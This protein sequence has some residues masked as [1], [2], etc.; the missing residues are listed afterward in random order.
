[1]RRMAAGNTPNARR[2]A[3]AIRTER[4]PV[5]PEKGDWPTISE[6]L[7]V[8]LGTEQLPYF[9][10]W[11]KSAIESYRDDTPGRF[12]PSQ[13]VILIGEPSTGKNFT[14][15]YIITP[16][17][18]RVGDPTEWLLNSQASFNS[19]WFGK[20]HLVVCDPPGGG[21]KRVK[22]IFGAKLKSL[23]ANECHRFHAKGKDAELMQ[24][25][26]VVTISANKNYHSRAILPYVLASDIRDKLLV[27]DWGNE[28]GPLPIRQNEREAFCQRITS[29]LPS[30]AYHILNEFQIPEEITDRFGRFAV[31]GYCA[32][33]L[34]EI[35]LGE[36]PS[37]ELLILIRQARQGSQRMW[38]S[39]TDV[40]EKCSS[41]EWLAT[42]DYIRRWLEDSSVSEQAQRFFK[43]H[44]NVGNLLSGLA[45]ILP[46]VCR[47]DRT[48]SQRF[49][50]F[51]IGDLEA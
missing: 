6:L 42:H 1:M 17:L 47:S 20:E 43:Q 45:D 36:L 5:K 25:K 15:L 28:R 7:N 8:K 3:R 31:N 24:P 40:K 49:W 37:H 35:F 9:L 23:A 46:G 12:R 14:Q 21:D 16:L 11:L 44:E 51:S 13:V 4:R 38:D 30:F 27:F 26:F 48:S 19:D 10:A 18:G 32:P 2:I 50:R 22:K 41:S 39:A 29:E 34:A 33:S